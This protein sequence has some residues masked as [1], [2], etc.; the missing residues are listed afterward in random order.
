MSEVTKVVEEVKTE[1]TTVKS[2]VVAFVK[3]Y[4]PHTV[5]SVVS[6]VAGHFGAISLVLK[7]LF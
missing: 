4:V 6:Y 1:V 2:K 5:I 7:H 3:K